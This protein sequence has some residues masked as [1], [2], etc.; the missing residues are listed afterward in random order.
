MEVKFEK[1]MRTLATHRVIAVY[2]ISANQPKQLF[3]VGQEQLVNGR[4]TS[5]GA[6]F[7]TPEEIENLIEEESEVVDSGQGYIEEDERGNQ[8]LVARNERGLRY[9]I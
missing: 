1:R 3:R 6:H 9:Y 8:F 4:F 2:I 5:I 7:F